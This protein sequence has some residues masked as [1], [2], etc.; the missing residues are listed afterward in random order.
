MNFLKKTVFALLFASLSVSVFAQASTDF[1]T[2]SGSGIN[3]TI[4]GYTGSRR[5]VVI[6][7]NIGGKQVTII[8]ASAF[9]GKNLTSAVIPDS[10]REIMDE[11]FA[12]NALQKVTLGGKLTRVG[13]GAFASNRLVGMAFS[14]PKPFPS[15]FLPFRFEQGKTILP[16]P[17]A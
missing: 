17:P 8:G 6:P 10:V 12:N 11:A 13:K 3:L 14:R 1:I 7:G 4:T 2:E 5:D 15:G 16:V 9:K